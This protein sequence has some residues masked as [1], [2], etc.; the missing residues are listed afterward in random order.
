MTLASIALVVLAALIHA[1]WN[2]LAK[3]AA[4]VGPP[5]VLACNLVSCVAY[6]PGCSGSSPAAPSPGAGQCSVL[7]S[8]VIQL[9]YWL[10]LQRGY[11]VADVSVVYPVAAAPARCS[12]ASARCS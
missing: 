1:T 2:L 3:R 12:R 6:A 4:A 8:G 10:A 5:F 9:R 11:Q 7:A